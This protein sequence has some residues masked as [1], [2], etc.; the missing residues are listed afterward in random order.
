MREFNQSAYYLINKVELLED[1]NLCGCQPETPV[2]YT[3]MARINFDKLNNDDTLNIKAGSIFVLNNIYFDFD[4]SELLPASLPQLEKLLDLMKGNDHKILIM[5]HTDSIGTDNYNQQLSTA[6]ARAVYD[7]LIQQGINGKR[8]GYKGYG[9]T[10]PVAS[11]NSPQ[12]R[13]L[14]RRVEIRIE[15]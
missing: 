7:W 12:N 15:Q 5:G 13:A 11:N 10:L 14:N 6:R 8:L 1:P 2:K 3:D 4:K 9:A